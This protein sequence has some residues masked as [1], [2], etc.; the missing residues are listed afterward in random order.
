MKNNSR[1]KNKT[2]LENG[3]QGDVVLTDDGRGWAR[4]DWRADW[5]AS[6][7]VGGWRRPSRTHHVSI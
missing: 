3:E 6:G 4:Q 1:E 7:V 2:K 5:L